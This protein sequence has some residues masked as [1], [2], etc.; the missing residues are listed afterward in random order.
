MK[1]ASGQKLACCHVCS[2]LGKAQRI[3]SLFYTYAGMT[4]GDD[5]KVGLEFQPNDT[6]FLLFDLILVVLH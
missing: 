4:Q 3:A 1:Q 5:V 6:D 2:L